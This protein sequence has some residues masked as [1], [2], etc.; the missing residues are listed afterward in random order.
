VRPEELRV[1]VAGRET[2][3]SLTRRQQF[4]GQRLLA[5]YSTLATRGEHLLQGLLA[6]TSPRQW[7]HYPEDDAIDSQSGY[8]WFYHSH[9]P[10]DRPGGVEHGHVHLFA[11]RPLWTRRTRSKAEHAFAALTG[12]TKSTANTRHLLTIGI[13]AEGL[14]ISLFTVNSWVTGDLMLSASFTQRLLIDMHL[15]TGHSEI[16]AVI[17]DAVVLCADEIRQLLADRDLALS[18]RTSDGVLTDQ[19]LEVLSE[20]AVVLDDKLASMLFDALQS[21]LW[22]GEAAAPA[23]AFGEIGSEARMSH[24][25]RIR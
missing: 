14:P 9:A 12:N 11:R 21:T 6:C 17:E 8:Q 18:A 15:N 16:D 3:E 5:T 24:K 7:Q 23:T 19:S 20:T 10:E 1:Q 25:G 22:R 4:A 2:S 13:S